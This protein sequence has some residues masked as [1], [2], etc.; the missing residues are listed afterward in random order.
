MSK[1]IYEQIKVLQQQI[2]ALSRKVAKEPKVIT[3]NTYTLLETDV[4]NIYTHISGCTVTVPEGID[5]T[6]SSYHTGT[7]GSVTFVGEGAVA[8]DNTF[9]HN[10]S[11]GAFAVATLFL[12]GRDNYIL[13]GNTQHI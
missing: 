7:V 1:N 8:I 11:N 10:S 6:H 12:Y 13:G 5:V 3:T 4:N 2:S 9:S